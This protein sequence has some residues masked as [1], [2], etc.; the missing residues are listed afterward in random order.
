M[1]GALHAVLAFLILWDQSDPFVGGCPYAVRSAIGATIG[2]G[3]RP[4]RPLGCNRA[5]AV[6]SWGMLNSNARLRN[7]R[8]ARSP[9]H[10]L[11]TTMA[12]RAPDSRPQ[13]RQ[14]ILEAAQR[15]FAQKGFAEVSLR[16]LTRVAGVNLAAVHYHFGSKDGLALAAFRRAATMV[17]RERL[18][19]L[20][21]AEEEAAPAAASVRSLAAALAGPAIRFSASSDFI[22]LYN[23]F[24]AFARSSPTSEQTGEQAGPAAARALLEREV[25]H[26]ERFADAFH[27]A[28]PHLPITEIHWRLH[29]AMGVQHALYTDLNRLSALSKGACD[30]SD[31]DAVIARAVDFIV[32]GMQASPGR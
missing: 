25:G 14:I 17:N 29:F 1:N 32:A 31:I 9:V 28:L 10:F 4:E 13:T 23:H 16:E 12:D 11:C 15:L 18:R 22:N 2:G 27:R 30:R 6:S 19:L 21:L 3:T 20:R 7:K 8:T 5:I 24:V 26:L